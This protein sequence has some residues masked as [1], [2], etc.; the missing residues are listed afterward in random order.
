MVPSVACLARIGD[1]CMQVHKSAIQTVKMESFESFKT[2][3]IV[4]AID[5]ACISLMGKQI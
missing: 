4:S 1:V 5:S 3:E 2:A